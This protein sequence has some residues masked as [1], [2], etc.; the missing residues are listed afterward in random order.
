MLIAFLG[1]SNQQVKTCAWNYLKGVT[2]QNFSD[3]DIQQWK[4]WWGEN[5]DTF[6][7]KVSPERLVE[8]FQKIIILDEFNRFQ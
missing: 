7:F 6:K 4:K 3:S 2:G 8:D 1:H 5:R